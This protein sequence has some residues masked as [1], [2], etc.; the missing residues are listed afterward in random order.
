MF[1]LS[2]QFLDQQYD[3]DESIQSRYVLE[4]LHH[5]FIGSLDHRVIWKIKNSFRARY[6]DRVEQSPY[7]LFDDRIYYEAKKLSVF[8]E[9][10]NL[11]DRQYT[12]VMTPMP[13]RWV[14]GGVVLNMGF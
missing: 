1:H 12:E 10:S 6:V 3:Q 2:Y 7:W 14:R 5:Q 9:A 8:I 11:T 4:N 13:G